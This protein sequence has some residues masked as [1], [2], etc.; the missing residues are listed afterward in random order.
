MS[1]KL[2]DHLAALMEPLGYPHPVA[3]VTLVETHISW[4]LLTGEVAYKI[5]RPVCFPFLDLRSLERR[6]F[7][8][9]EE[10]RLNRRFAPQLYM[11][12]CPIASVEGAARI[13]GPG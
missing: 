2:P 3:G 8:C 9:E 13:G 11:G 4:I 12:V 5:K 1:V 7:F 6:A 10:V